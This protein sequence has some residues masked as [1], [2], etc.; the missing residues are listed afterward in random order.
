LV[1]VTDSVLDV[2]AVSEAGLAVMLTAGLSAGGALT[3]VPLPPH[4]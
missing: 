4:P 2:P 3:L 1:A